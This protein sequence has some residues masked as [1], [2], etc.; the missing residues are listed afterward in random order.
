M[1]R[2]A[3]KT[4]KT[5]ETEITVSIDLD[6]SGKAQS[7]TGVGFMDHMLE[8]MGKHGL[9]DIDISARGD[10][11]VDSHHT[12]E[13]VG[14]VLGECLVKALGDKRGIRRFGDAAVPMDDTLAQVAL[15]LSGRAAF[16]FNAAFP[17]EKIGEFDV[18]LIEEFLGAFASNAKISLHVNVPYGRNAHH[19]AEAVFKALARALRCAVEPDPRQTDVPST[20]GVL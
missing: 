5:K 17:A 13:D 12:V 8:L 6:G 7:A 18:G 9:L 19:V 10:L 16:V 3:Q 1:G 20:K 2:T 4:R 11:Q 14:I 15:D